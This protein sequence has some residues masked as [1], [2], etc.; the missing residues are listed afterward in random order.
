MPSGAAVIRYDG[1]RGVSWR[2]KFTDASGRQV[3]ETL[4]HERDG[5]TR[6]KAEVELRDRLTNDEGR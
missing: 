3:K 2:I 5:W 6:K 4:G 1:K